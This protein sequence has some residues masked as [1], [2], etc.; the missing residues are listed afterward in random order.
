[1]CTFLFLHLYRQMDQTPP[2]QG[3]FEPFPA[4]C[5]FSRRCY[6]RPRIYVICLLGVKQGKF[7]EVGLLIDDTCT[8]LKQWMSV[9]ALLPRERVPKVL[10]FANFLKLMKNGILA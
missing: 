3:I 8:F 1:M 5:Y 4:L 2:H 10:S 6:D 9:S 7:P